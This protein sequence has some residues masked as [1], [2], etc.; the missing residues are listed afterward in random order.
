[1]AVSEPRSKARRAYVN[2]VLQGEALLAFKPQGPGRASVGIRINRVY[3]FRGA[4]RQGR[5]T[6]AA[7][8]S[9]RFTMG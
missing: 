4:V 7:L 1:M 5:F 8:P 2:G 3:P 9:E 6:P